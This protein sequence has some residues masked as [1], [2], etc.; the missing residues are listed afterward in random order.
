MFN[1]KKERKKISKKAQT[2]T[3]PPILL[4]G[5][6]CADAQSGNILWEAESTADLA[7]M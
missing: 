7:A 1:V 2:Y 5:L 6:L 4:E 3:V